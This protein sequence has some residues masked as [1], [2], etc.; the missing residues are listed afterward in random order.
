SKKLDPAGIKHWRIEDSLLGG[1]VPIAGLLAAMGTV[2]TPGKD[3][4]GPSLPLCKSNQFPLV[5]AQAC[6]LIDI[7]SA[8]AL[9]FSPGV[10]CDAVSVAVVMRADEAKVGAIVPAPDAG[11]DC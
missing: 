10:V 7:S 2:T 8:A 9:D 3:A 4:G 5:K 1:R 11:N 6:D